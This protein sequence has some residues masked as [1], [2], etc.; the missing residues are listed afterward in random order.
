MS[1]MVVQEW[2]GTKETPGII[3]TKQ[4]RKKKGPVTPKLLTAE[5]M[6]VSPTY[7]KCCGDDSV[8]QELSVYDDPRSHPEP[9]NSCACLQTYIIQS[10]MERWGGEERIIF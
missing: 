10:S 7:F 4:D 5:T 6:C 9:I 3:V 8:G 1:S 2:K